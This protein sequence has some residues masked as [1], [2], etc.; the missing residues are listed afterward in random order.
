YLETGFFTLVRKRGA[1]LSALFIGE[2]FTA[3]A[4]T[5]YQHVLEAASVLPLF[6]PLIISSGGNSG[7]QASTL[8]I[9]A[10]A[11]REIGLRDWWRVFVREIGSGILL[12]S[13]LAL[14]GFGRIHVWH[15]F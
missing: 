10:M 12:G 2:M 15:F 3:S 8:V 5:H 11:L 7:S 14:L 4:M 9:R 6:I 1:W 13:W